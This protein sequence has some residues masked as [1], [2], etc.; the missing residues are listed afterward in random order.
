LRSC[1]GGGRHRGIVRSSSPPPSRLWP[2]LHVPLAPHRCP[3]RER[4]ALLHRLADAEVLEEVDTSVTSPPSKRTVSHNQDHYE[5]V[6][7]K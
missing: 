6:L 2:L 4:A 3:A 1:V 7:L 5:M